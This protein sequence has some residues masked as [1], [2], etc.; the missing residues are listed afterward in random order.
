MPFSNLF[1]IFLVFYEF[2]VY[3]A[4]DLIMPGMI[5]VVREFHVSESFVPLSLSV[6]ILGGMILQWILGPF[7]DRYGRRPTMIFGCF[8]FSFFTLLI[9]LSYSIE[10]FLWMRLFQGMGMCFITVC[11]YAS[12]QE[13]FEEKKAIRVIAWMSTIAIFAPILGPIVGG[14]AIEILSWRWVFGVL[15]VCSLISGMGLLWTMPESIQKKINKNDKEEKREGF[16]RAFTHIFNDGVKSYLRILRNKKVLWGSGL[17]GLIKAPFL[18]WISISPIVL[19]ERAHIS[20]EYYGIVQLPIFGFYILGSAVLR[21][22][23]YTLSLP[24]ILKIG[25]PICLIAIPIFFVSLYFYPYSYWSLIGPLSFFSFGAGL[26]TAPLNRL[27]L[28]S[29][30]EG[31]GS[32]SAVFQFIS[33]GIQIIAISMMSFIF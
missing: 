29:S 22:F 20:A 2:T 26:V 25:F 4:N 13:L 7:S 21:K 32:V 24:K 23:T 15:L 6:Y 5:H 14:F 30:N 3:M 28:Y 17:D 33:S 12:V 31:K 19:F 1:L 18:C 16:L 10:S 8:Y 9:A 11:G 27:T